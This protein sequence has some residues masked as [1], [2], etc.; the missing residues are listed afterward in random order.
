M[1]GIGATLK[2]V[3]RNSGRIA[4]ERQVDGARQRD[5]R[6]DRVDVL[7]GPLART[8]AR[9]EAAVLPHV[10]G[11]VI[12]I[13]DDR[14]VEVAEEDD[15]GDVEQVVE[16]HAAVELVDRVLHDPPACGKSPAI[17][18]GNARIDDAKM[19]GM[20]PPVLT[21]SG[22]CVLEPPYIRRPTTRLAYCTVTRRWPRS[23]KTIAR[24]HHDHQHQQ[25]QHRQQADLARAHLLERLITAARQVRRR[26]RRR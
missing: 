18:C 1:N 24:D 2:P 11:H 10:L 23:T 5:P 12:R 15:A 20:T 17:V 26:C 16:R 9:D 4:I 7:R 13:E 22:M 25:D 19:T 8:D 14:R 3:I 21:F 6:Q